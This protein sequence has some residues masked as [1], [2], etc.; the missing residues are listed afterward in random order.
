MANENRRPAPC[1]ETPFLHS[2]PVM[3]DMKVNLRV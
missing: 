2:L 1:D 3:E